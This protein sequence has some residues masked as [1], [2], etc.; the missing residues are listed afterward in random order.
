LGEI[1]ESKLR[2]RVF[3]PGSQP[4]RWER[5]LS[6]VNECRTLAGGDVVQPAHDGALEGQAAGSSE[7]A[8]TTSGGLGS[9]LGSLLARFFGGAQ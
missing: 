2:H 7:A 5:L 1:L 6:V 8:S 4:G 9:I 3:W